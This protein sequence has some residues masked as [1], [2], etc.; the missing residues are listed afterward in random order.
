MKYVS[1]LSVAEAPSQSTVYFIYGD[2][3]SELFS[4]V[5]SNTNYNTVVGGI[6][7]NTMLSTVGWNYLKPVIA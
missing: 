7:L 1:S 5:M 3:C 6:N 2:F 4:M